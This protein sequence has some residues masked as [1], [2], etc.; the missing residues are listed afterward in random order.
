MGLGLQNYLMFPLLGL[1]SILQATVTSRIT[2]AGV[3]PDLVLVIIII[4]TLVFGGRSGVVWAFIGGIWLDIFSGGPFGSSSLSLMATAFI[5]GIGYNTLSRT[6]LLIP[7]FAA[8]LGTIVF[9]FT[10]LGI[11]TA[12]ATI[13]PTQAVLPFWPT[14]ENVVVPST[15]Y[16]TLLMLLFIPLMNRIPQPGISR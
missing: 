7:L 1:A 12:V 5:I 11:L 16:N 15:F 14:V 13:D 8:I 4:W 6:N 10:Y 3:K 2:I 9:S